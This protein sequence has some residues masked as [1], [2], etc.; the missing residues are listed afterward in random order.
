MKS[1]L[2]ALM[3]TCSA[4]IPSIQMEIIENPDLI[5]EGND[6]ILEEVQQEELHEEVEDAKEEIQEAPFERYQEVDY[7]VALADFGYIRQE[8]G[9]E[10]DLRNGILRFQSQ[11]N[12]IVDGIFGP[13]S[14]TALEQFLITESFIYPD[15]VEKAPTEAYWIT[16]NKTKRVLTLYQGTQVVK[17]YPIAQGKNDSLTPV[18]KFTIVNKVVNPYWGGAGV[19]KP[20]QG[21]SPQNPLGYRWMGIS[22][23]G[24]GRYGIHGNNNPRSIG[25]NASL[26]CV[27]MINSDVE[28]LFDIVPI[29]TIV[30]IGSDEKLR[31]WGVSQDSVLI[32]GPQLEAAALF[33]MDNGLIS[34]TE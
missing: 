27:R 11:H 24:G 14:Q 30:W 34:L 28:E 18:G 13:Q 7:Q 2:L 6:V 1:I 32:K 26:G 10:I 25:T 20:V 23:G 22:Y 21:G 4:I 33:E 15:V 9:S 17:K 5:I 31:E 8:Y 19:A 29:S 16:I 3:L 12:L